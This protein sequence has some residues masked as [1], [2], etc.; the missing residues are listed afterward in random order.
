MAIQD[1]ARTRA[2]QLYAL[3]PE[4][5]IAGRDALVG[6]L[7]DA[8]EAELAAAVK[9]L[10]KP[11]IV[12]WAV[13]A[14]ARER[15]DDVQA[16]LRAGDALRRAQQAA[17]AGSG[18]VDL[19]EATQERRSIIASLADT[20]A[21]ALGARAQAHRDAIALTLEA[22]SVDRE[23][24]TRLHDATLDR[25]AV[26]GTGLDSPEGL[27]LIPGGATDVDDDGG[28]EAAARRAQAHEADR[29][30][31]AAERAALRAEQLRDKARNAVVAA[32]AAEA[33]ARRL[34]DEARTIRRR[35][36]RAR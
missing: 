25:E 20:A 6:E 31:A 14:A 35:A 5:F 21:S 1:E 29:A 9:K 12:A 23:L 28:R 17:V 11:S 10:R 32:D 24:G 30:A 3:A 36:T 34:A 22:A 15:P 26:P 8:G 27:Q 18:D 33:E 7:T 19:R 4:G 16:L 2:A 13:N